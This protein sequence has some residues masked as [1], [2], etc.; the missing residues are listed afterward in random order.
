ME[1]GA[2]GPALVGSAFTQKWGNRWSQLFEQTRRTMPVTQPGRLPGSQYEQ[3]AALLMLAN[4][5]TPGTE[6]LARVMIE[7]PDGARIREMAHELA[8]LIREQIGA[9]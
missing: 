6:P 1:G 3:L 2:A 7:G 8:N 4:G 5:R 9:P